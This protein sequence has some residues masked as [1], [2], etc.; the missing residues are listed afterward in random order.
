M[1]RGESK[2][3]EPRS[4][5]Y[6]VWAVFGALVL[7]VVFFVLSTT[8]ACD[9]DPAAG[10]GDPEPFAGASAAFAELGWRD[11][12]D[13]LDP[14]AE[15]RARLA[16][17]GYVRHGEPSSVELPIGRTVE[18]L[19]GACGV[20]VVVGDPGAML[21]RVAV[22]DETPR[23]P[24]GAPVAAL[25]VCGIANVSVTGTGQ[26]RLETWSFPGLPPRDVER[27]GIEADLLL[28]H[29][30]AETIFARRGWSP[31]ERA[32]ITDVAAPTRLFDPPGPPSGCVPFVIA[33]RGLSAGQSQW[34]G[35][36]LAYDRATDRLLLGV[37]TCAGRG[38]GQITFDDPG[39]NG[40]RLVVLPYAQAHGPSLPGSD[41]QLTRL[42]E[43]STRTRPEEVPLPA[44]IE[45]GGG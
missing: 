1:S 31:G 5:A 35:A 2:K 4:G 10:S 20:V 37:A 9:M 21:D 3:S 27:T 13:G 40:G 19:E 32:L 44:P 38:P 43:V 36:P 34:D 11:C 18:D 12:V 39:S 41:A 28:A 26:A 8:R 25:G 22:G 17:R 42:P 6:G 29:A 14:G 23:P 30:E 15:L 33:G 7:G 24:C 45:G 16:R